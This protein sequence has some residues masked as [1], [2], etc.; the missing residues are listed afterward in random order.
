[1]SSPIRVLLLLLSISICLSVRAQQATEPPVG[2]PDFTVVKKAIAGLRNGDESE[3][4]LKVEEKTFS[5][6]QSIETSIEKAQADKLLASSEEKRGLPRFR[7][8]KGKMFVIYAINDD[9]SIEK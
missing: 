8:A 2:P 3:L 1:M 5:V 7:I 9:I 4:S 6:R